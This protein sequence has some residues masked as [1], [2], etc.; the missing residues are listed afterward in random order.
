M[1]T[2]NQISLL[3]VSALNL[4]ERHAQPVCLITHLESS[5]HGGNIN[6]PLRNPALKSLQLTCAAQRC[7]VLFIRAIRTKQIALSFI[8]PATLLGHILNGGAVE[9]WLVSRCPLSSVSSSYNSQ[10]EWAQR[11]NL[12]P[13]MTRAALDRHCVYA[14]C[15]K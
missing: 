11:S 8:C 13:A 15:R 5:L 4:K 10:I 14:V 12:W 7:S 3:V 2:Q 1:Q 6:F 9:H